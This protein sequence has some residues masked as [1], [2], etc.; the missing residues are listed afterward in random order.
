M[1]LDIPGLGATSVCPIRKLEIQF[2]RGINHT[3]LALKHPKY[4]ILN[5]SVLLE[6]ILGI[7][8]LKPV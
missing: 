2:S 5:L 4:Q 6:S 8:E 3:A 1:T 7:M